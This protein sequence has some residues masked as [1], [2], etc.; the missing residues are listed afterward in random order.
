[1]VENRGYGISIDR[2]IPGHRQDLPQGTFGVAIV[3]ILSA[4]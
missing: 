2:L 4:L 1:M 3:T